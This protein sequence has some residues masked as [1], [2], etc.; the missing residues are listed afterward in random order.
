MQ[1]LNDNMHLIFKFITS[2]QLILLMVY[3]TKNAC[4][5]RPSILCV[6][7]IT[8]YL[9]I[10][11][12]HIFYILIPITK[13]KISQ[14]PILYVLVALH[15]ILLAVIVFDYLWIAVHDPVDR[16]VYDA[17]LSNRIQPQYLDHC[18]ICNAKRL[19]GSHHCSKCE[20]CTQ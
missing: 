12:L 3:Q 16:I 18:S 8:L 7:T 6:I 11:V 10:T 4:S 5:H 2:Y 19:I 15:F 14:N 20:R 9:G 1:L 13:G 17:Q